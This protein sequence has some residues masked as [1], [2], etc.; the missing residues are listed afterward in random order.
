[1]IN[2][3]QKFWDSKHLEKSEIEKM[4][5]PSIFIN[6]AIKYFPKNA[7][8]LELGAGVGRDTRLLLKKD[9]SV[10]AT[11]FSKIALDYI[12]KKINQ[13]SKLKVNVQQLDLSDQFPFPDK[14]FDIVYANLVIHYF[15]KET[16][17]QIFNEIF[18]VLK[19]R[20]TV[21]VLVNSMNDPEYGRGRKIEEDFFEIL[22]GRPKRYFSIESLKP[23]VSKFKTI[24]LD[25]KG[26]DPKRN[27]KG[28]LIRFIGRK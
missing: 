15:N 1:M 26:S 28:N 23:F 21:A 4:S 12:L 24:I 3:H 20:G 7:Y 25:N 10:L 9:Y 22:P 16:T 17:Q 11:D 8:I 2:L 19:P 5:T 18:R 27:N 13:K 14:T 6:W